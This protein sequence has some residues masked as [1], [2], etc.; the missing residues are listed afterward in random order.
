M[1]RA[2]VK[3]L[4]LA[5]SSFISRAVLGSRHYCK[6]IPTKLRVSEAV[7]GLNVGANIK[8]QVKKK[9]ILHA[10]AVF[11][12]AFFFFNLPKSVHQHF[13]HV[14]VLQLLVMHCS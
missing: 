2:A 10:C 1:F 4:S 6:K 9:K 13:H 8:V 14:F 12:L 7:S 11:V 3:T 5:S